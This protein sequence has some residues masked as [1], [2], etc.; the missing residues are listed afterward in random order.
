[1]VND[2]FLVPSFQRKIEKIIKNKKE[3]EII[4]KLINKVRNLGK[5]A[6]KILD[7]RDQ[8]L[9]CEMKV[10]R[11][12]YRLY[13]MVDQSKDIF[14]IVDWEHKQKQEKVINELRKKLYTAL[15]FGMD[16]IFI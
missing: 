15:K 8:Y 11:P 4:Y 10:K 5:N 1:M 2:V 6:L 16:K 13:V 7:V 3:K 9:L 14:Y 12:P